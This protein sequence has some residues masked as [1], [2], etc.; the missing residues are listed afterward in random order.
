MEKKTIEPIWDEVSG[1]VHAFEDAWQGDELQA[2]ESYLPPVDSSLYLEVL[3]ELIRVELE[4]KSEHGIDF[5]LSSYLERFPR[6]REAK[7]KLS[8]IAYEEYRLRRQSG[9][10]ITPQWYADKYDID[11]DRWPQLLGGDAEPLRQSVACH[12]ASF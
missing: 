2:L 11:V 3:C 8:E 10:D 9:S 7:R 6:L 1:F 12:S 4:R 5:A